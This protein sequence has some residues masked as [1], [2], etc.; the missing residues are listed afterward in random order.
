MTTSA[1]ALNLGPGDPLV[2]SKR[3][4]VSSM[5]SSEVKAPL[6]PTQVDTEMAEVETSGAETILTDPSVVPKSGA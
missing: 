3:P 2:G 1:E 4:E 6:D 5:A